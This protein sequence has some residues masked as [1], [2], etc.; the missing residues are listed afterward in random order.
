MQNTT[1]LRA[2]SHIFYGEGASTSSVMAESQAMLRPPLALIGS[3]QEW[4]ARSLESVLAPRG[5]GVVKAFT[6]R[7]L[8]ARVRQDSPDVIIIEDNL[9]DDTALSACRSVR[10]ELGDRPSTPILITAPEPW[11]GKNRLEALR[12]GA[13]EVLP[14]PLNAE[15]LILRL[16]TYALAKLETDRALKASLVDTETGLLNIWGLMRRV[17]ELAS[18]AA[19]FDRPISCLVFEPDFSAGEAESG[20]DDANVVRKIATALQTTARLHDTLGRLSRTTIVVIAPDTEAAGAIRLAERLQDAGERALAEK[21]I[22]IKAGLFATPNFRTADIEAV[23]IVARATA[24]LRQAQVTGQPIS[25]YQTS[26][27]PTPLHT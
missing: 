11:A 12:A 24:A 26:P 25:E 21:R 13:W 20:S 17:A 18:A 8:L 19:R 4:S 1:L 7:Q 22:S 2:K 14:M 23:E 5:Y 3:G 9:S 16:N 27:R 10:N 15:E 6:A